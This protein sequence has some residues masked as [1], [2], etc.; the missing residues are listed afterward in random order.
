[1]ITY[2]HDIG[3][4]LTSDEL[5]TN[6]S[7]LSSRM[8]PLTN[9]SINGKKHFVNGEIDNVG[10]PVGLQAIR[11]K[12][13]QTFLPTAINIHNNETNL[14]LV[15]STSPIRTS[16]IINDLDVITSEFVHNNLV[17]GL[18][19]STELPINPDLNPM[20]D[21]WLVT[22]ST[23]PKSISNIYYYTNGSWNI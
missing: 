3:R 14:S 17:K 6:L 7:T 5:D 9:Q 23:S 4:P 21:T 1:M 22:T 8:I 11:S 16:S 2:Q 12:D 20:S 19:I 15:F 18:T 13:M 10:N